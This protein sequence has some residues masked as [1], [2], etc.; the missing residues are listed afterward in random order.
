[1]KFDIIR[2]LFSKGREQEEEK[3]FLFQSSTIIETPECLFGRSDKLQKLCDYAEGL[4]QVQIIGARRFGKTCLAKSFV[5]QEKKNKDRNVNPVFVDVYSDEI[6][7]TANVYRYLSALVI[8]NLYNDGLICDENLKFFDY[9]VTPHADWEKVFKQLR[10]IENGDSRY[11]FDEIVEQSYKKTG[12]TL[13]L[14]FDEYEKSTDAFDN[15]HGFRH[16]RKLSEKL[17]LKFWIVGATPWETLV[18]ADDKADYRASHVFNGVQHELYVCPLEFED[19]KIMWNNECSLIPDDSIRQSFESLC[20]KVYESSGGVPC[21]AKEIGA[22]TYIEGTYPDYDC[23][24]KHFSEIEKM[25]RD[26]ETNYLRE[27]LYAPKEYDPFN[28]PKSIKVLEKYGLVKKDDNSKYAISIRFFSD[29]LH[30]RLLDKQQAISNNI[31]I[32][33]IVEKIDDT[34]YQINEKWN[35]LYRMN[36]FDTTRDT[37]RLYRDLRKKCDCR[38]KAP[39]FINSIYLLY[40][41]GAKESKGG[42]KIPDPFKWTM[43][44]KAMDRIRHTLGKA[45]Q[46]DKLEIL[47]G[48]IDTPTALKDIWGSSIEPRTPNEWLRFQEC[49]LNCFMQ[50]LID[51]ND[52][53]EKELYENKETELH[54]VDEGLCEGDEY[55]GFV[56][57]V[58]NLHG[59]FLKIRC[60]NYPFPLQIKS[61]KEEVYA[62]EN[63]IFRASWVP[64]KKDPSKKF[65]YAEDVRLK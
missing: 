50:E 40:W 37:T 49:M 42:D 10:N 47:P 65:W 45:H 57:E 29:Y 22:H 7:G 24:S 8:S 46:Q 52:Y 16:L 31:S 18:L 43:F 13:L 55:E 20:D 41:E 6:C 28:I 4:H 56:I 58:K 15:V 5:T 14:I 26:E 1:M 33:S 64:N 3:S 53:I 63:V 60:D 59:S 12:K 54:P 23:L 36:M 51:L 2:K 48:Q 34:F 35:A 61:W 44:R 38:E 21:F 19:F 27:L 11:F 9:L 30:A 25:L 32:D 17:S 62:D 39:N